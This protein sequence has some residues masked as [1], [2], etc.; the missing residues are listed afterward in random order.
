MLYRL[1]NEMN[2]EKYLIS[3]SQQCRKA[4]TLHIRKKQGHMNII[5]VDLRTC[6][7]IELQLQGACMQYLKFAAVLCKFLSSK[8]S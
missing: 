1:Y 3:N 7:N 4:H 6:R 2:D 8:V 5:S